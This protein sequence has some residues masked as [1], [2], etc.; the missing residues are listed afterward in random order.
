VL[1]AY[2]DDSGVHAGSPW[3]VMAGFFGSEKKWTRFDEKWFDVLDS[4]GIDEFHAN[5]FWSSVR[6]GN[7]TEYRGWDRGRANRFIGELL[8]V[9]ENSHRIF[10]VSCS[11]LMDE[12]SKLAR[13]ERAYLTGAKHDDTGKL[14]TPGAPNKPYFLPFLTAI[15][16]VMDYCN[17]GQ[18]VHFV[19]DQSP[20][21]S[22]Y[23][24]KYFEEIKTWE[25]EKFK[26]LGDI[27]FVDSKQAAPIQAADLLA[28]ESYQYG[29]ARVAEN[30]QVVDPRLALHRAIKNIR[31]VKNDSKMFDKYGF[32]LV[33]ER[34]RSL[35]DAER[36]RH[37]T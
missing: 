9:I 5:R 19:F 10:P 17:P 33:L 26:R 6:G 16:T 34:F 13:D 21:F 20:H 35:R 31:N 22:N 18:L 37:G 2:L 7:I 12:W 25:I 29:M 8:K 11:V 24:L 1:R 32:D 36:I 4:F 23:A 28:F 30:L 15:S 27:S 3:C 14:L